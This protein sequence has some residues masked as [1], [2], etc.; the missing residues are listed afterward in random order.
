MP[1]PLGKPVVT[2]TY[3]DANLYHDLVTGRAVTGVLHLVNGT[4]IEWF[5]KR[6]ATVETATYGSEFVAARIATEQIIDLRTTLRYLGVEVKSKSYMF[7]DNQSVVTSSTVPESPLNKRHNALSYHRVRE[8]IAAKILTYLK[9]DGKK[10][11]AD[12]LSKHYDFPSAWPLL[13]PL[14]FWRGNTYGLCD[15][16]TTKKFKK[17]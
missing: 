11:V 6:Q 13:K 2:T 1:A 16:V 8:A 14:L 9:V 4:P 10:N 12:V 7:G 15:Q 3:V 5:S 17:D